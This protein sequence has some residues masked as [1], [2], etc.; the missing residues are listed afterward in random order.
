MLKRDPRLDAAAAHI[1]NVWRRRSGR[2]H[3]M[4]RIRKMRQH[5]EARFAQL[6]ESLVRYKRL[7]SCLHT[8]TWP[9]LMLMQCCC[10]TS[11]AFAL[12]ANHTSCATANDDQ[13]QLHCSVPAA[14]LSAGGVHTSELF[15]VT[16]MAGCV[17]TA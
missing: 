16:L 14:A 6:Q 17:V 2:K 5:V 13:N 9:L 12:D 11:L 1:Q 10:T 4:L 15:N 7:G 3:G 8:S